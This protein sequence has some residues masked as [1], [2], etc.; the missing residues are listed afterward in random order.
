[1]KGILAALAVGLAAAVPHAV[2]AAPPE[3]F[4]VAADGS[5]RVD[6]STDLAGDWSPAVSPDGRR[7]AFV[8]D[9]DGFEAL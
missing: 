9:R 2:S 5:G 1:M 7:V 6:L 3:I 8:S 4:S